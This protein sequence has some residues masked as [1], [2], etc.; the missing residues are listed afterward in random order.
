MVL[1]ARYGTL[2]C[3]YDDSAQ[4]TSLSTTVVG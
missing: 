2:A 4:N 1:R 3:K